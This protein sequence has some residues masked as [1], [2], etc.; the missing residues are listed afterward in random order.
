MIFPLSLVQLICI[1]IESATQGE[2]KYRDTHVRTRDTH[3][4]HTH[5]GRHLLSSSIIDIVII[6][7][8]LFI[9]CTKGDDTRQHLGAPLFHSGA[10]VALFSPKADTN[11]N[12]SAHRAQNMKHNKQ[13]VSVFGFGSLDQPP[14][15]SQRCKVV[16]EEAY[17]WVAS[18]RNNYCQSSRCCTSNSSNGSASAFVL[19]I[20]ATTAVRERLAALSSL[21]KLAFD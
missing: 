11:N 17:R 6:Q 19:L 4:T 21:R 12:K 9:K 2:G 10:A 3:T 7:H 18:A 1:F 5:N 14:K 8:Q 13:L 20:L 16:R 15:Y